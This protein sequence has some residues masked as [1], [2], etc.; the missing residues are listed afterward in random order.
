MAKVNKSTTV[1]Q[2]IALALRI[3]KFLRKTVSEYDGDVVQEA[4]LKRDHPFWVAL[5][6]AAN[7][8]L[9]VPFEFKEL[10]G[11]RKITINDGRPALQILDSLGD[12][13]T[14]VNKEAVRI[15]SSMPK[16]DHSQREEVEIVFLYPTHHVPYE[17]VLEEFKRRGLE[18]ASLDD[19]LRFIGNEPKPELPHVGEYYYNIAFINEA[20]PADTLELGVDGMG[21]PFLGKASRRSLC[22]AARRKVEKL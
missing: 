2:V 21:C 19:S 22:Y 5:A 16:G 20:T 13:K 6:D 8:H 7:N 11:S 1:D 15:L 12:W 9:T 14:N 10:S 3:Y 4:I 17:R 18:N